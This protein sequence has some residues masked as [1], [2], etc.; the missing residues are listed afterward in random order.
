[1]GMSESERQLRLKLAE[2]L[3]HA[4]GTWTLK[5]VLPLSV[6]SLYSLYSFAVHGVHP[7]NAL[8][9]Y[10]PFFGALLSF[11]A[12]YIYPLAG[13]GRSWFAPLCVLAGFIP[14]VFALYVMI[15][16]GGIRLYASLRFFTLSYA[17]L[18]VFWLLIGYRI[19]YVYWLYTEL[20]QNTFDPR[21][22]SAPAR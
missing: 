7:A 6:P 11:A 20:V 4:L 22:T 5:M 9:T 8:T 1:M 17:F 12:L 21:T 13:L 16:L 19:L 15:G 10:L 14:Y 2:T 3:G 18:G